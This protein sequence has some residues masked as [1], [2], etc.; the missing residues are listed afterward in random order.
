MLCHRH[1]LVTTNR[2][3]AITLGLI[4]QILVAEHLLA[5]CKASQRPV[6][7]GHSRVGMLLAFS[8]A[9]NK[10]LPGASETALAEEYSSRL[11]KEPWL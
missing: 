11:N 10:K 3:R 5:R 7:V 8:P 2:G 1:L 4:S 6:K 9:L